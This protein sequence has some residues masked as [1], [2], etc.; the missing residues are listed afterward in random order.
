VSIP[1]IFARESEYAE[2]K[3]PSTAGTVV[4]VGGG[5]V[6]MTPGVVTG[7]GVAVV[8]G[9]VVAVTT[10]VGCVV[11]GAGLPGSEAHPAMST[12]A[13]T[14]TTQKTIIRA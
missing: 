2:R 14:E 3:A 12:P 5:I 1:R 7:A 9:A 4:A 8:G 10:G 13:V 6:G 11:C